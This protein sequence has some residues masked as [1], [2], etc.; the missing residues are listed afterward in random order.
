LYY[1]IL[2]YI[3]GYITLYLEN[4]T[5]MTPTVALSVQH[6]LQNQFHITC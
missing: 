6:H 5:I 3:Y 1:D 4:K 2:R